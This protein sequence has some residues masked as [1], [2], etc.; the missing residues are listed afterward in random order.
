MHHHAMNFRLTNI[1]GWL[2]NEPRGLVT[3]IV[4]AS[5]LK[6]KPELFRTTI[7]LHR[8]E[9]T[10]VGNE[11]GTHSLSLAKEEWVCAMVSI[12]M[13]STWDSAQSKTVAQPRPTPCSH[14][15]R[16]PLDSEHRRLLAYGFGPNAI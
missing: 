4:A 9:L 8:Y 16:D 2:H 10:D 11:I 1:L 6:L 7:Y 14:G 3:P 12:R 15:D 13:L 5:V